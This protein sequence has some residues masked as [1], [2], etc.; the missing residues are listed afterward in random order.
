MN[1]IHSIRTSLILMLMYIGAGLWSIH[2]GS[3]NGGNLAVVWLASGIGLIIMIHMARIAPYLVFL[4]SF[5][6]NTPFYIGKAT[7]DLQAALLI[8]L[9]TALIDMSQ[10]LIARHYYQQFARSYP[11][12]TVIPTT[13]LPRY[14]LQISL[15]PA[16]LTSP[17]LVLLQQ[18]TGL[19]HHASTQELLR[20]MFSLTLSDTAGILL[21]LPV[22]QSWRANR[23]IST[24][25]QAWL[26]L[27]GLLQFAGF[28]LCHDADAAIPGQHAT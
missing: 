23:I 5:A 22:Y 4:S 8:G 14:W 1:L 24:L 15:I 11:Q 3:L 18:Y 26:P 10:S 21:L 19:M 13:V 27:L 25:K 6:V 28:H 20:T 17:L 9:A 2:L 12:D 16:A 7:L